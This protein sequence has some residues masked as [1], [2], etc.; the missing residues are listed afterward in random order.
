MS[1][2]PEPTLT[3]SVR[4]AT[5]DHHF[6]T[7]CVTGLVLAA[8]FLVP[9]SWAQESERRLPESY[10]ALLRS[11]V[12]ADKTDILRR[13][14]ALSNDDAKKFWPLQRKYEYDL[15][16]LGDE[17]LD[18]VRGYA[19]NW[20]NMSDQTARELG[21][22]FLDYQKKRLELHEKYFDRFSKE[23]SPTIAAKFF[24]I[25]IQMENMVDIG[26]ASAVPLIQ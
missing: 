20:D 7:R 8:C 22:R 18:I 13:K 4:K 25:E 21:K 11:D 14:L 23:L 6:T 19:L 1:I 16:K 24:Q 15:G 5:I 12:Q 10:I 9:C 26:I 3:R 2:K 17:H